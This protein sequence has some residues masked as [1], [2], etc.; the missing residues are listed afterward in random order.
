[1]FVDI[2]RLMQVLSE[3]FSDKF[4]MKITY[5]ATPKEKKEEKTA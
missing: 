2:Q 4:G 5:S 1:M 3:I